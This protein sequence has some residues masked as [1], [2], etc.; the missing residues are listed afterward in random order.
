GKKGASTKKVEDKNKEF[1]FVF[2]SSKENYLA[3]L[4]AL[5]EKHGHSKYT[6]VTLNR[7][8][9]IKV[10]VPPKKAKKDAI[11]VDKYDE[12]KA[13]AEK[14]IKDKPEKI[15]VSFT[16]EDVKKNNKRDSEQDS[17]GSEGNNSSDGED[18]DKKGGIDRELARC[19]G[20]L[21]KKYANPNDGG[22]TYVANDG[23]RIPLTPALM[24]QWARAMYDNEATILH[25]PNSV[26]FDR[27]T[28][29]RSLFKKP[30]ASSDHGSSD[31]GPVLQAVS[32]ILHDVRLMYGGDHRAEHSDHAQVRSASAPAAIIETKSSPVKNTPT[33][34]RRYLEYAENELGLDSVLIFEHSLAKEGY[35]P[36]IL[37]YVP[38][39]KLVLCGLSHGDAMRLKRGA[40]GWWNG[41]EAKR[42]KVMEDLV[43]KELEVEKRKIRFEKRFT[44]G[45]CASVFGPGIMTGRNWREDEFV[46]WYFN[47][48]TK[49]LEK[50]PDGYI[51]EIDQEY[52]D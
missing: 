4:S 48:V 13:L 38:D 20:K 43:D 36:D 47:D 46:W 45:G 30:A 31:G 21:E 29:A 40:S 39:E 49:K 5:V 6:P 3:F 8:F 26:S 44:D 1:S 14:I 52:L 27:Q 24:S 2:K 35:G 25:P 32:S 9:G 33:K 11:D 22:Y 51:P 10:L 23:E 12:F 34:L 37:P 17:D 28:R 50:V 42:P 19:R 18:E 15:T 41:P 16:L 7:R